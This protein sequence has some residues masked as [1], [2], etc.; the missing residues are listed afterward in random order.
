MPSCSSGVCRLSLKGV[1]ID[2]NQIRQDIYAVGTEQD[3][4]VA[5][6]SAWR[7]T[8]LA[9]GTSRFVVG[10]SDHIAGVINPPTK[11]RGYWTNPAAASNAD[12]WMAGAKRND[13]SW[14]SDWLEWLRPR[15]GER[16]PI[17]TMGN[18]A[19]PPLTPAPG[20]YVLER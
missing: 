4:I 13:G 1:P 18:A 19:H 15:S 3:H 10:G 9:S 20:S 2:L 16:V 17:P 6:R 14:W 12:E 7:I 8:Q 5:W 11:G